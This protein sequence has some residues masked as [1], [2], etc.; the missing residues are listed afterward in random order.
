[1]ARGRASGNRL[2]GA[3]V[4]QKHGAGIPDKSRWAGLYWFRAETFRLLAGQ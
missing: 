1:M 2:P 3:A 4:V